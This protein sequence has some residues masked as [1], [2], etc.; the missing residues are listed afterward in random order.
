MPWVMKAQLGYS[1]FWARD[2]DTGLP[3]SWVG[4]LEDIGSVV[5]GLY[6]SFSSLGHCHCEH[7]DN[8]SS[9]HFRPAGISWNWPRHTG[10]LVVLA[11]RHWRQHWDFPEVAVSWT[12]TWSGTCLYKR[13]VFALFQIDGSDEDGCLHCLRLFLILERTKAAHDPISVCKTRAKEHYFSFGAAEN[14]RCLEGR[15]GFLFFSHVPWTFTDL[16]SDVFHLSSLYFII[17][18]SFPISKLYFK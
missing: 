7:K 10:T 18:F 11:L 3:K 1:P 9:H 5:A 8:T 6:H 15:V 14:F 17:F 12:K 13:H 16:T 4:G 2:E